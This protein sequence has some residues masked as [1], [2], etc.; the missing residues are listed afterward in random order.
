M[1]GIAQKNQ[2][3]LGEIRTIILRVKDVKMNN[4]SLEQELQAA[5]EVENRIQKEREHKIVVL[6]QERVSTMSAMRE[7]KESLSKTAANLDQAMAEAEKAQQLEKEN[8]KIQ[9]EFKDLEAKFSLTNK[10]VASLK[11]EVEKITYEKET[12]LA[13]KNRIEKKLIQFQK[14][15][16]KAVA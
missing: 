3:V 16:G 13:E 10:S 9:E 5:K 7:L 6:E 1:N 14:N 11:T 12:A 4:G 8:R 15:W 2:D